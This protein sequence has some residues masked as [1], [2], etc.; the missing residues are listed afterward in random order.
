MKKRLTV[1]LV[2]VMVVLNVA[3]ANV[4]FGA[5][6]PTQYKTEL[7]L[8]AQSQLSTSICWAFAHNEVISANVAKKTGVL[9]DFSEETAKF[10]TARGASYGYERTPNEGGNEYI[11]TA[12]LARQGATLEKDEPFTVTETR[13]VN[14]ATLNYYGYLKNTKFYQYSTY[15]SPNAQSRA[16]KREAIALIKELVYQ[17][18]AVGASMYFVAAETHPQYYSTNRE[19]Y[20]YNGNAYYSNHSVTIVGWDDNYSKYNFKQTPEANGAFIVKNSWG[21][22]HKNGTSCYVYVSYYDAIITSQFFASEYEI[23]NTLFNNTYQYDYYGWS[24][25]SSV[26]GGNALCVT[27]FNS[28][29]INEQI[30]AVSTYVSQ[31][32]TTVEVYICQNGDFKNKNAYKKVATKSVDA[33]GYY[34]IDFEAQ[35]LKR[36]EYYVAINHVT[37]NSYTKFP[38]QYNVDVVKGSVTIP[39]TCYISTDFE[40]LNALDNIPQLARGGAMLTTKAFTR[41]LSDVQTVQQYFYDVNT[42]LWYNDGINY[43]V[44]RNI[45]SGMGNNLFAP[46]TSMTRAMFVKVLANISGENID[47]YS[48]PFYDVEAASWYQSAVAWGYSKGIV[49]G[50][51]ATA[52][53]P[54]APIT[55]EQMCA[56]IYRFTNYM[57]IKLRSL[58]AQ[59]NF[60]DAYAIEAYAK[61]AVNLCA[62]G[63]IINGHADGSFTPKSQATRAQVAVMLTNLC[64]NYIY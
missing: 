22:Y 47:G 3:F 8:P 27:K 14:P 57:G 44:T 50:V 18:G 10:E 31:P 60:S 38:L 5:T 43:C 51:S 29:K 30:T 25:D 61:D 24:S 53:D 16:E 19:N 9:Y 12:Y 13:T 26:A 55:R 2:L 56:L 39:D 41:S 23:S 52:F 17:N 46:D 7:L 48:S 62:I 58:S 20:Y 59:K 21:N 11:S 34:V 15:N 42:S 35:N 32:N 33:A 28:N 63:G 54:N 40:T 4:A 49:A 36:G 64:K 6:L 1:I 37:R 45:F